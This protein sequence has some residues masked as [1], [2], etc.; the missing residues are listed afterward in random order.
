MQLEQEIS[1]EAFQLAERHH[2]GA[3]LSVYNKTSVTLVRLLLITLFLLPFF[4]TPIIFTI[5]IFNHNG[6]LYA[7]WPVLALVGIFWYAIII[8][9][10]S[11]A[12]FGYWNRKQQVHVFTEGFI[13]FTK[14]NTEVVRWD[15]IETIWRGKSDDGRVTMDSL[16]LRKIDGTK[17]IL[18]VPWRDRLE[19]CETI[20]REFVRIRLPGIIER[21]NAGNTLDF[22]FLSISLEGITKYKD[23]LPLLL[24]NEV[25]SIKVGPEYLKIR[26]IGRQLVWVNYP[27][28][29]I[30]NACLLREL[31]RSFRSN[32]Q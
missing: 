2:L 3:L 8:F 29:Y 20:E 31:V 30:P 4:I 15:Q 9:L 13:Y 27:I 12:L 23:V 17:C 24:W 26:K 6:T 11:V 16:H 22:G 1:L 14:H 19:V 7:P 18:D 21:Y 32:Q 25:E 28:P 5:L 10:E